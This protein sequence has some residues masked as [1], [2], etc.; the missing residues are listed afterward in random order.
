MFPFDD[1]IVW[2]ETDI[3]QCECGSCSVKLIVHTII[4]MYQ[5]RFAFFQDMTNL[6]HW[7]YAFKPVHESH[8]SNNIML[9]E[10]MF[11]NLLVIHCVSKC[12]KMHNTLSSRLLA[13]GCGQVMVGMTWLPYYP[14]TDEVGLKNVGKWITYFHWEWSWCHSKTEHNKVISLQWHHNGCDSVSNH[15]PHHC[16]P[17]VYSGADQRK[18]QSSVSLAFVRG[19]PR[20]NGQ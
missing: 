2:K 7:L 12:K 19:I 3:D 16:L 1:V 6:P 10:H 20:T 15:Q 18:H 5:W 11:S 14:I 13:F 9:C 17:I 8:T 4:V